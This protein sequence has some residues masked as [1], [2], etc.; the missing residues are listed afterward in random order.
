MNDF[1]VIRTEDRELEKAVATLRNNYERAKTL[2]YVYDPLAWALYQ[3]WKEFDGKGK[4][5][6][7]RS[8]RG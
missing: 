5:N 7:N 6:E 4:M 2:N 1:E 8:D 3:T